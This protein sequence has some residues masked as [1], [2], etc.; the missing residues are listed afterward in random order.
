MDKEDK[1]MC[2]ICI[3]PKGIRQPN[4]E[5]LRDMWLTNPHGAG[6]MVARDG[7]VEIH[8]GFMD[9]FE[10]LDQIQFENFTD[11]DVV[12]YHFRI[13]TQ[14]GINPQM[15]HPFPY[16]T[17]TK[18]LTALDVQCRVGIA[19]NGIIRL[20]SN[21]DKELSDTAL[22]IRDYLPRRVKNG[23]NNMALNAIY[24]DIQSRMVFLFADGSFKKVGNWE[25]V[26]GLI[27]SNL[28]HTARYLPRNVR[29]FKPEPVV[30]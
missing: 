17:T 2:V 6:Y 3:S 20:T 26:D 1:I 4:E 8:K 29:R 23:L 24:H 15:C 21:G 16:T 18:G 12:V 22:Y 7:N 10:F 11:D 30:V 9:Y 28:H 25:E 5:E 14:G 27:Y 13:A 19:H